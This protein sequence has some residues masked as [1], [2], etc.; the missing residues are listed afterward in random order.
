MVWKTTLKKFTCNSPVFIEGLPG[1]GNV[2]KVVIDY[3]IEHLK[4]KKVGS[5]FSYD[6]PNSV[7]VTEN[8]LVQLP[9]I[10]LYHVCIKGQDFLMLTGD[11]QP[12]QERASFELCEELLKVAKSMNTKHVITLGGIGMSDVPADPKVYITGNNKSLIKDF[13]G[14]NPEVYGVVGPIIGVS[15]LLLGLSKIPAVCLLGE[16]FGHPMYIGLREAKEVLKI[17]DDRYSLSI[18]YKEIDEEIELVESELDEDEVPKKQSKKFQRLKKYK[19]L[20]Y[21]G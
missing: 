3:L 12:S 16:T 15:G 18:D 7:F 17:I 13:K 6:M 2:G 11:A 19:D 10:D 5:F 8:N 21:I 1:I 14:V 20:N 9:T 4:A